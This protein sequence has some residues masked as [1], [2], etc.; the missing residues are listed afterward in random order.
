MEHFAVYLHGMPGSAKELALFDDVTPGPFYCPEQQEFGALA[1]DIAAASLGQPIHLI[2]FSLG[3]YAA[4]HVAQLLKERVAKV[5]L[6]SV[7]APLESGAYL[8]DM[9]GAAVFRLA[10]SSPLLFAALVKAQAFALRVAPQRLYQALFAS[11]AGADK[12]LAEDPYFRQAMIANMTDCLLDNSAAYRREIT[13]YVSNWSAI[14]AT[15]KQPVTLWHGDLDNWSPP[16]MATAVAARLPNCVAVHQL[17]GLSHYSTL[18][19]ALM[20]I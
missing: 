9:A 18:R 17:Q 19:H 20:L 15:I 2:G 13:G 14:L 12:A 16:A 6:I 5:D 10:A 7:A 4:L 3:T 8:A 11:A 1:D